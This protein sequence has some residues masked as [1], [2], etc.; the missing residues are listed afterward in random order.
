MLASRK[1]RLAPG[2]TC[3]LP[4]PQIFTRMGQCYT[5]NSGADGAEL[6]STPKGG[7]GNGLEVMLD[8]QQEEYLPVWRDVGTGRGA[9]GGHPGSGP[10]W[11]QACPFLWEGVELAG[12]SPGER[13]LQQG[14]PWDLG[15]RTQGPSLPAEETPFEVGVRVQIHTQEELPLIDQLGFGAAPGY[16]TFVSCQKQQASS[17]MPPP[18]PPRPHPS[19][20]H[21]PQGPHCPPGSL[22]N[23]PPPAELP[24]AALG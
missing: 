1:G 5:F 15:L 13:G 6:L 10:T 8:V 11:S 12:H 22:L 17:L 23:P 3:P 20:S 2:D 14:G 19:S 18:H 9:C 21:L 24:A 16:Q 7:M 4:F